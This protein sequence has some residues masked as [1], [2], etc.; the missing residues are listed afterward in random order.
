MHPKNKATAQTKRRLPSHC[1][2]RS[3]KSPMPQED[4]HDDDDNHDD[5]E[6]PEGHPARRRYRFT[7]CNT[8]SGAAYHP[9]RAHKYGTGV[10]RQVSIRCVR[11]IESVMQQ[12]PPPRFST[13][14]PEH[15]VPFSMQLKL[16]HACSSLSIETTLD[17]I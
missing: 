6:T 11:G 2:A 15:T 14:V 13:S 7:V 4:D 3:L 8:G 12:I 16:L 10:Q 9:Q 5:D 1:A 17:A